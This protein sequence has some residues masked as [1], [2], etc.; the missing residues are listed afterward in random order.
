MGLHHHA[1]ERF[2]SGLLQQLRVGLEFASNEIFQARPD[3]FEDVFE[4][5]VEPVT[6]PREAVMV[7]PGMV[8]TLDICSEMLVGSMPFDSAFT[9]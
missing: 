3:V 2:V 6:K 7:F 1:L 4:R 5:T 8:S 9:L